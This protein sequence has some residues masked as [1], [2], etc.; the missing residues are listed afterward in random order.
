MRV[1]YNPNFC[2]RLVFDTDEL[3]AVGYVS[4]STQELDRLS[5]TCLF[6]QAY[7][8]NKFHGI[9][10]LL[11][12]DGVGFGLILEGEK[13]QLDRT[14]ASIEKDGRHCI[15]QKYQIDDLT[16]RHFD[17]WHMY[18]DGADAIAELFPNYQYA[19]H[20]IGKHRAIDIAQLMSLYRTDR[21]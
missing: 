6:L 17:D 2:E 9:T 3:A 8:K 4:S 11:Y 15:H 1:Q 19:L 21:H 12:Y 14:K 13:W 18:F 10:G 7:R 16:A 5:L 20:E